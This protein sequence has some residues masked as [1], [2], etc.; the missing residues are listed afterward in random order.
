MKIFKTNEQ[1]DRI[2]ER[3]L[4]SKFQFSFR[5]LHVHVELLLFCDV[6]FF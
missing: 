3:N 6:F 4:S 5:R 2:D 1:P